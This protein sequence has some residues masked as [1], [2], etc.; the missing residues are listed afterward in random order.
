MINVRFLSV[1]AASAGMGN[2]AGRVKG[3]YYSLMSVDAVATLIV[4]AVPSW[5]RVNAVL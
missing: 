5:R 2:R 1:N 4:A 3:E